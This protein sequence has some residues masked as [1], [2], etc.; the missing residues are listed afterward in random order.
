ME[1]YCNMTPDHK[2]VHFKP[3]RICKSGDVIPTVL[4]RNKGISFGGETRH[5]CLCKH[6]E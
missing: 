5:S 2:I 1:D 3:S 6:C 4:K